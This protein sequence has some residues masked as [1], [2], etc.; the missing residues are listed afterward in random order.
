VFDA[1]NEND[2]ECYFDESPIP[3]IGEVRQLIRP[4]ALGYEDFNDRCG[5]I[6]SWRFWQWRLR[7]KSAGLFRS[8]NFQPRSVGWFAPGPLG[9]CRISETFCITALFRTLL[10]IPS[11]SSWKSQFHRLGCRP[12]IA[13]RWACEIDGSRA[14]RRAPLGTAK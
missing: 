3:L 12:G 11:R 13:K 1:A 14:E 4:D 5:T 6:R 8:A 2:H 10:Q 7:C 9:D